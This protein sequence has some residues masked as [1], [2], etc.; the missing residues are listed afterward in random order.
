[1]PL[2]KQ[3]GVLKWAITVQK[4]GIAVF[5]KSLCVNTNTRNRDVD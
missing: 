4:M 1:M 2:L 5:E 3:I